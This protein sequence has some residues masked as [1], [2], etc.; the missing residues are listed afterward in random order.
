MIYTKEVKQMIELMLKASKKEILPR[1]GKVKAKQKG[2]KKRFKDIVTKADIKT[3][4]FILKNI[5][6]K[7][8]GSYSEEHKYS[9]RFNYDLIWQIFSCF[10]NYLFA[11]S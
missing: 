4:S 3:S 7:F 2:G 5:R 1:W 9:D 10:R 11:R 6:K 8:P